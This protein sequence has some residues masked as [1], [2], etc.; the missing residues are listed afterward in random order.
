MERS[1][2]VIAPRPPRNPSRGPRLGI[3][4]KDNIHGGS[5]GVIQ[6]NGIREPQVG[7]VCGTIVKRRQT[8]VSLHL[9]DRK[10]AEASVLRIKE[11]KAG[12]RKT[13]QLRAVVGQLCSGTRRQQRP[14]ARK[15]RNVDLRAPS[16]KTRASYHSGEHGEKHFVQILCGNDSGGFFVAGA[17]L[18]SKDAF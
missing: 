1:G 8:G 3:G 14:L 9:F 18:R 4:P 12:T 7:S 16:T 5:V 6:R 15:D 17:G 10:N 2:G 13:N 11:A